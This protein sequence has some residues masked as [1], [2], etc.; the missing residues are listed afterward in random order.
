MYSEQEI[1][2]HRKLWTEALRSGRFKQGKSYLNRDGE[3]CCLGVACE[4]FLENG[5]QMQ[6]KIENGIKYYSYEDGIGQYEV[7]PKKVR[8]WL[9]I[10]D[11]SG[12][13]VEPVKVETSTYQKSTYYL[14]QLNDDDDYTFSQIAD[15]IE[16]VGIR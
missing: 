4:V 13:L 5:G 11:S 6:T 15:V 2:A 7:L 10:S 9:G 8:D 16:T 14:T 3:C 1:Q 12:L